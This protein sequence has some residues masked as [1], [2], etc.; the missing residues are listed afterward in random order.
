MK[1]EAPASTRRWTL[2]PPLSIGPS[3]SGTRV[4][5][6][7][8]SSPDVGDMPKAGR[9][10]KVLKPK[11]AGAASWSVPWVHFC[12]HL[13]PLISPDPIAPDHISRRDSCQWPRFHRSGAVSGRW[14]A[15]ES[16]SARSA[17]S[18]SSSRGSS[19][20]PSTHDSSRS[21]RDG[22]RARTGPWR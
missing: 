1:L 16:R 13:T 10:V 4:W 19:V 8:A 14:W 11:T 22:L 15:A 18:S 21:A 17:P 3:G 6:L 2:D 12:E 20:P 7:S 5:R 9:T